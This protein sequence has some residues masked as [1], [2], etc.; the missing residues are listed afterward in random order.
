MGQD[1]RVCIPRHSTIR[2][3]DKN[4]N[5]PTIDIHG[6]GNAPLAVVTLDHIE[7][8]LPVGTSYAGACGSRRIRKSRPRKD[9][10]Q[11]PR[12]GADQKGRVMGTSSFGGAVLAYLL[13][14]SPSLTRLF[15]MTKHLQSFD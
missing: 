12:E 10:E 6:Y 14:D 3:R 7:K 4:L 1:N 2:R 11:E 9:G 13:Q 5:Q 8:V 15:G